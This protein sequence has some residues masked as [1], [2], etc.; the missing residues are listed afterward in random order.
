[1]P[2]FAPIQQDN[3]PATDE[4]Q[5]VA[6][7][8]PA[9]DE[10]KALLAGFVALLSQVDSYADPD[11]AQ[12]DGIAAV[13]DTGYASIN[14]DGCGIPPECEG[15]DSEI[16]IFPGSMGLVS[17]TAFS[18]VVTAAALH[19]YS[20]EIT[21]SANGNARRSYRYMEAGT[22]HYRLT[23]ATVTNG[24]ALQITV[25]DPDGTLH[26]LP[27][28]NMRSAA[29]VWNVVFTGTFTLNQAGLTEIFFGVGAGTTG[30]FRDL[31]TLLEMWRE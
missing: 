17:G 26:V 31:L 13:F 3:Y 1:M 28:I 27:S 12:A 11:S 15:M 29:T 22:W 10:Y 5:C 16:T 25:V 30:G 9:G 20:S 6:V 8:I 19:N 4:I 14:W 23:G 7:Y 24:C 21:P 18:T 2:Y